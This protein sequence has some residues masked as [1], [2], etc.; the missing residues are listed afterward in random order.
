MQCWL[1]I[2]LIHV[3]RIGMVYVATQLAF[4]QRFNPQM[5]GRKKMKNSSVYHLPIYSNFLSSTS[6]A[7]NFFCST[8]WNCPPNSK[9]MTAHDQ[10]IDCNLSRVYGNNAI[11]T[12]HRTCVVSWDTNW[13]RPLTRPESDDNCQQYGSLAVP[14]KLFC[15]VA[16]IWDQNGVRLIDRSWPVGRKPSGVKCCC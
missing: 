12:I 13:I 4:R 15:K 1:E 8:V 16:H 6:Q 5:T 2:I 3:S 10:M 7:R 9:Q 11:S 14:W